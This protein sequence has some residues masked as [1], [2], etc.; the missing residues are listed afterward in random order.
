MPVRAMAVL[1]VCSCFHL[2]TQVSIINS[3]L[4]PYLGVIVILGFV[5]LLAAFPWLSAGLLIPAGFDPVF[6]GHNAWCQSLP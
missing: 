2:I 4:A 1:P 5:A 3:L 6:F